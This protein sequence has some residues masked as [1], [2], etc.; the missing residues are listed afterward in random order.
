MKKIISLL[1]LI[2]A[3]ST[4]IAQRQNK[5]MDRITFTYGGYLEKVVATHDTLKINNVVYPM[6]VGSMDTTGWNIATKYDIKR[7]KIIN[8]NDYGFS[9]DS[10][11]IVNSIILNRILTG[12]HRLVYVTNPGTYDLNGTVYIDDSTTLEFMKGVVIR[13][14]AAYLNVFM[15]RGALTRTWNYEIT[16]K[17]LSYTAPSPSLTVDPPDST[18]RLWGDLAFYRVNGLYIYNYNTFNKLTENNTL[19]IANFKNLIIDGFHLTGKSDAI[20]LHGGS[21]F[22]IRNGII[23]CFDDGIIFSGHAFPIYSPELLDCTDGLIENVTD[24][25]VDSVKGFFVRFYPGSWSDWKYGNVY[26]NGDATSHNGNIY[27]IMTRNAGTKVTSTHAP[28]VTAGLQYFKEA[29]DQLIFLYDHSDTIH[30]VEVKRIT[31]RNIYLQQKRIASFSNMTESADFARTVYPGSIKP[32]T[33]EIVLENIY[34]IADAAHDFGYIFSTNLGIDL[35]INGCKPQRPLLAITGDSVRKSNIN[36]M[37]IT[38]LDTLTWPPGRTPDISIGD[39]SNVVLNINGFKQN[40]N[41]IIGVEPNDEN[42]VRV[43]GDANMAAWLPFFR[44]HTGD[45]LRYDG[46]PKVYTEDGWIDLGAGSTWTDVGNKQISTPDTIVEKNSFVENKEIIGTLYRTPTSQ[47]EVWGNSSETDINYVNF[48][49]KIINNAWNPFQYNGIEFWNGQVK[50]AYNIPSARIATRM[51]GPGQWGDD[52]YFQTQ[53]NGTVNPNNL[54]LTTKM[55]LKA[56]G[57]VGIGTIIPRMKLEVDGGVMSTGLATLGPTAINL[58]LKHIGDTCQGGVV[59]YILT[60]GDSTFDPLKQRVLIASTSNL[61]SVT[62]GCTGVS[63]NNTSMQ[64][65]S[66]AANTTSI[67]GGC[68]T[69]GIAAKLCDALTHNGY[70]DWYLP[71]ADELFQMYLHKD[72]I[73]TFTGDGYWSSSQKTA[74]S[75]YGVSF[76]AGSIGK[77]RKSATYSVRPIRTC[78][79]NIVPDY[80]LEV[81][82]TINV[83]ENAIVSGTMKYTAIPGLDHSASGD[84]ITLTAY[85]ATGIGDVIYINSSAKAALCK[86]DT[87]THSPYCFAICADATIAANASGSWLTKGSIR[88]DTW[89]WIVGGL[90]YVSL[91]GTTGNTLTQTAPTGVGNVVMPIGVALSSDVMYFF[92]NI[93]SVEHQ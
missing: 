92:G 90:I 29:E 80:A 53:P 18:L 46:T 39:S 1:I 91:T 62:W 28:T 16:L 44:P 82:G 56:D 7:N 87:I 13:K 74:D 93:N 58:S 11:G 37:N 40:R 30:K 86:A 25:P 78:V 83:T 60:E 75:A 32:R 57:N 33:Q 61:T 73:G 68:V 50:A 20:G 70:S 85:A 66:G 21:H 14:G 69:S 55:T 63:I 59:F 64:E 27:R 89:N 22:V 12:G 17:G 52:M 51:M 15:N 65:G 81:N 84:I 3:F 67:V 76:V 31:F 35:T 41:L 10:T 45:M 43:M 54:P 23:G 26:Q 6:G 48:P 77:D 49:L 24:E 79:I 88:D 9:P 4:T 71:S 36:L 38:L 34:D 47:L 5:V 42:N 19:Q 8:A 72:M 2:S